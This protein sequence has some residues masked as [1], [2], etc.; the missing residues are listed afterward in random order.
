MKY[1]LKLQYFNSMAEHQEHEQAEHTSNFKCGS[2]TCGK[3]FV[4]SKNL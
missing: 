4:Y 1:K 3:N 2:E